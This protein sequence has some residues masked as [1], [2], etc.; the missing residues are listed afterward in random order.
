MSLLFQ[1]RVLCLPCIQDML[2]G[3]LK[4]L[5]GLEQLGDSSWPSQYSLPR[6]GSVRA[7]RA[8]QAH[9]MSMGETRVQS[10]W[11]TPLRALNSMYSTWATHAVVDSK[12]CAAADG[13]GFLRMQHDW[14]QEELA[15]HSIWAHVEHQEQQRL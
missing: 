11:W 6:P 5:P 3:H 8:Q 4:Q 14:Q 7:E 9:A 10:K 2:H 13:A 12:G 1:L 15:W